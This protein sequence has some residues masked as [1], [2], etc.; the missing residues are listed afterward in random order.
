MKV[1]RSRDA[2]LISSLAFETA[3]L[4]NSSS[5]TFKDFLF[6]DLAAAGDC[7]ACIS[8]AGAM[9]IVGGVFL[10]R[11]FVGDKGTGEIK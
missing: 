9:A 7:A 4:E 2:A 5:K 8:T 3:S 1:A 11:V 6:S 10:F